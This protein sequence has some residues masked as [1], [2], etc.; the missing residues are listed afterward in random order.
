MWGMVSILVSGIYFSQLLINGQYIRSTLS[1]FPDVS[2]ILAA[3]LSS[4]SSSRIF[5]LVFNEAESVKNNWWPSCKYANQSGAKSGNLT[6]TAHQTVLSLQSSQC[7]SFMSIFVIFVIFVI[8]VY[9]INWSHHSVIASL[10]RLNIKVIM[11]ETKSTSDLNWGR[12][13]L[14]AGKLI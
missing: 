14:P 1:L 12:E 7:Q 2:L 3:P 6:K 8:L 10:I 13:A 11:M 4:G 9:S 5:W